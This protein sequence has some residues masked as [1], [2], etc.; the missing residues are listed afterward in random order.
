MKI[1]VV[2]NGVVGRATARCW[3]E[4]CDEV[5]ANDVLP[6]RRTHSLA[7]TLACDMVFVCLPT[8]QVKDDLE[9]DLSA[10]EAF[11]DGAAGHEGGLVL[12]STVPI[13]TT[14]RLRERYKLPGLVHSPEFLTARCALIDA[15]IP[16][17]NLIG[18]LFPSS[19][20]AWVVSPTAVRLHQLYARRFPGTLLAIMSSDESEAVKLF[21]NGFFA[22]KV[23]YWNECRTLADKLRL[24]W[25][26]VMAGVLSDGRIAHAHTKVPGPDGKRGF[27]GTCLPKDAAS[28]AACLEAAGLE[29]TVTRAALER[30]ARDREGGVARDDGA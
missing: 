12:K 26:M 7:D 25:P 13:G 18:G 5:R 20:D 9:C 15:C 3:M 2:G 4:H 11:C 27:G 22:V 29:A 30:N 24:N 23:A 6:E 10:V 1:G 16:S 21:Q 17:R 19:G 14:R 8:P 28:L